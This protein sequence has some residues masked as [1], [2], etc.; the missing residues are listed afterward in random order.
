[1]SVHDFTANMNAEVYA[2][3]RDSK[4]DLFNYD[5]RLLQPTQ[6]PC[7]HSIDTPSQT[8]HNESLNM[9][10]RNDRMLGGS[11]EGFV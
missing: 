11:R 10:F 2:R 4:V 1:M 9:I 6:H 8:N 7:R 3:H 5:F